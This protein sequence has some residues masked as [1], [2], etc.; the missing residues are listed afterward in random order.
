MQR[1][2]IWLTDIERGYPTRIARTDVR[3]LVKL[4]G[5]KERRV[6]EELLARALRMEKHQDGTDEEVCDG[7]K[8]LL[9]VWKEM[10]RWERKERRWLDGEVWEIVWKRG[11][12]YLSLRVQRLRRI[13]T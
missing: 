4:D 7:Q 2:L 10:V 6:R 13:L 9:L 3:T 12:S 1:A 11:E 5:L 8:M